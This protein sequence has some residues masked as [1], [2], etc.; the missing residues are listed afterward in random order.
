MRGSYLSQ[1]YLSESEW[2]LIG[3]KNVGGMQ[4]KIVTTKIAWA[5]N[6]SY[7]R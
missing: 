7:N 2:L 1:Q 3:F 5:S 4:E 6:K